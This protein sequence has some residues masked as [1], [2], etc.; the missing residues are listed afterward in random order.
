MTRLVAFEDLAEGAVF[1]GE[2]VVVDANA[3]VDYARQYD[4]WPFHVDVEAAKQTA[5]G[6]LVASGG[7][8]FSLWCRSVHTIYYRTPDLEWAFLGGYDLRVKLLQPVRPGDRLRLK[9][10]IGAKR[11]STK[12]GRGHVDSVHVLMRHDA[13]PVFSVEFGFLMATRDSV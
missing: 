3:M 8:T 7:Y 12:P 2:E 9:V 11:P 6:G 1:W 10:S 5:F 4:P 13:V